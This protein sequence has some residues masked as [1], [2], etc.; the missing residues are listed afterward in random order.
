MR[1]M[2]KTYD[3]IVGCDSDFVL[4]YGTSYAKALPNFVSF[5]PQ[6]PDEPD[7]AHQADEFLAI[8]KIFLA[9]QVYAE[10]MRAV[11]TSEE[12]LL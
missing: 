2:K 11:I 5:G 6:F 7:T 10:Y 4:A 3:D 8:D 12:K 9:F 1:L